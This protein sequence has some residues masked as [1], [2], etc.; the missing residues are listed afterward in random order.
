MGIIDS[1]KHDQKEKHLWTIWLLLIA[2]G[3][4]IITFLIATFW[5][6]LGLTEKETIWL[7]VNIMFGTAANIGGL[8][9]G[10]IE[11]KKNNTRAIVGIIGNALMILLVVG[12]IG[13]SL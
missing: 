3:L 4:V 13:Y 6:A 10:I 11:R 5:Q 8:V 9:M 12:V 2:L 7:A 1:E